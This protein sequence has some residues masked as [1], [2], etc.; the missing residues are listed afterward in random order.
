[1]MLNYS[2]KNNTFPRFQSFFMILEWIKD[3]NIYPLIKHSSVRSFFLWFRNG[4]RRIIHFKSD[5]SFISFQLL[6][7]FSNPSAY[8]FKLLLI[9]FCIKNCLKKNSNFA[10]VIVIS[11]CIEHRKFNGWL[12]EIIHWLWKMMDEFEC[13]LVLWNCGKY[14]TSFEI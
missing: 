1:M 6:L 9:F 11:K 10:F 14:L 2:A 12:C 7:L 8:I 4:S 5:K 3:L 13:E